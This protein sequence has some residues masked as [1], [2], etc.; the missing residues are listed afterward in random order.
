MIRWDISLVRIVVK[1]ITQRS[2]QLIM[3]SYFN[4]F[5]LTLCHLDPTAFWQIYYTCNII[6]S[7]EEY[8]ILWGSSIKQFILLL[9]SLKNIRCFLN[10]YNTYGRISLSNHEARLRI[11]SWSICH[12]VYFL[13]PAFGTGGKCLKPVPPVGPA[14]WRRIYV[15]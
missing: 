8:L 14:F 12:V 15:D 13:I 2:L 5:W 3:L 1:N 4:S 9:N 6:S 10:K 11:S 7:H